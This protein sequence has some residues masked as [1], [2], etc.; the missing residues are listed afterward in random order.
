MA[1]TIDLLVRAAAEGLP[2]HVGPSQNRSVTPR[3]EGRII[4]ERPLPEQPDGNVPEVPAANGTYPAAAPNYDQETV[5]SKKTILTFER[6][7]RDGK[8]Y[9]YIK[10]KRTGEEVLRIPRKLL[11]DANLLPEL[12]PRVDFRI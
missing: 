3:A 4:P 2:P 9:L 1:G 11:D 12:S 8:L 10:D 5:L 6:D 7:D